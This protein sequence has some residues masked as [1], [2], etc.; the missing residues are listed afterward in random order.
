M[1]AERTLERNDYYKIQSKDFKSGPV[2]SQ[3]GRGRAGAKNQL[4]VWN[5]SPEVNSQSHSACRLSLCSTSW[6]PPGKCQANARTTLT[7]N[8]AGS[9]WNWLLVSATSWIHH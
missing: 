5:A 6:C 3:E 9:S 2:N 8:E 4:P 1:G 7:S